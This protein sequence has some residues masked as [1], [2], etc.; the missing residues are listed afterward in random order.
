M[1]WTNGSV[2]I[3]DYANDKRNGYGIMTYPDGKVEDG[4]WIDNVF[5]GGPGSG[6]AVSALGSIV[7]HLPVMSDTAALERQAPDGKTKG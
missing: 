4:R 6:A 3:G 1:T 5:Q 2:N 7:N